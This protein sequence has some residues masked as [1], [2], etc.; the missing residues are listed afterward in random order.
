MKKLTAI[1]LMIC[2]L[3]SLSCAAFADGDDGTQGGEARYLSW[4]TARRVIQRDSLKGE[5]AKLGDYDLRMWVPEALAPL[6]KD[7]LPSDDYITYFMDADK[8]MEVGVQVI[9]M[10]EGF[11]LQALEQQLGEMGLE[12][13]GIYVINGFYGLMAKSE[14]KDNLTVILSSGETQAIAISF[15]PV[16]DEKVFEMTKVML[17]SLQPDTP[18]LYNLADMIDTDLLLTVW[19]ENRKVNFNEADSSIHIVMWDEGV[20]TDDIQRVNNWSVMKQDKLDL[21]SYYAD[22][23]KELGAGDVHLILQ[24]AADTEDAAFLTIVDG[25]V[26][27]DIMEDTAA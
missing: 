26:V 11:T 16:S 7:K 21:F 10:G 13:G 9:E 27:Y 2:L 18:A 3:A 17:A 1:L 25:E 4:L 8:S 20:N 5:F 19:G 22:S 14:E 6:D 23:L 12:D 15:Y 24:L